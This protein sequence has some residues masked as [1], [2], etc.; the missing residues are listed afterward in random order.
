M[1]TAEEFLPEGERQRVMDAVR[2]AEQRTS[3]EIRIHLE[4]HCEEDVLDHAV[5]I[6]EELG[7]QRTRRRNGVLVYVS[8]ADHRLA[9]IGDA[10]INAR[11]GDGFWN[12]V[13][14]L[15]VDHFKQGRNADGLCAA[16]QR[17][18]DKLAEFFPPEA[19]GGTNELSDDI[20]FGTR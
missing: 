6:F 12:D 9:V 5:F 16:V 4:D 10:G 14:A 2:A 19:G 17:A 15:L 3:G 1:M 8:V 7:M 20:S 13:V 18:G 11:G